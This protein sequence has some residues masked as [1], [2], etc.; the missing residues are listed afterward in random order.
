MVE[1]LGME[2]VL[3]R[4][5]LNGSKIQTIYF[6]G[7]TPS[8]LGSKQLDFLLNTIFQNYCVES[9]LEVTIECNPEDIINEELQDFKKIG[10]NRLSIGIQTLD[11]K[12]LLLMNRNHDSKMSLRAL[13]KTLKY[14][15]GNLN[16]DL[17][18]G[19][20]GETLDIWKTNLNLVAQYNIKHISCYNLTVETRTALHHFLEKGKI[21][22]PDDKWNKQI[23]ELNGS[24]F[25]ENGYEHYEISNFAKRD[26]ISRHNSNYWKGEKYLGIGPS[27]HSYDG[28][29]HRSWNISNNIKY[30]SGIEKGDRNFEIEVLT[31]NNRINELIMIGCRTKWGIDLVKLD[32]VESLASKTL[33]MQLEKENLM[34]KFALTD[35]YLIL[36]EEAKLFADQI[37]SSLFF[38]D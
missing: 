31:P 18:Y 23:F 5:E 3:R 33:I 7:G 9:N 25:L 28:E 11:D 1:A 24:F 36:K 19:M 6:G 14:D 15:F 37:A 29:N 20:L 26:F 38:S 10:I 13:D 16:I 17:M 21:A 4:N 35:K 32:E 8:L 22:I 2:L 27:A 12:A 30:I 34:D